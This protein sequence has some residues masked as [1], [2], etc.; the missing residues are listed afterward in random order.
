MKNSSLYLGVAIGSTIL[1]AAGV[2]TGMQFPVHHFER[3]A[4]SPYLLDTSTGK[5]CAYFDSQIVAPVASSPS[6][7]GLAFYANAMKG[8]QKKTIPDCEQ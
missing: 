1:F 2:F 7:P 6:D 4:E 8:V 3:I 5:V